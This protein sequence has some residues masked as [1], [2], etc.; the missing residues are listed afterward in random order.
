MRIFRFVLA[1]ALLA[2]SSVVMAKDS[3]MIRDIT[4]EQVDEKALTDA[5]ASRTLSWLTGSSSN[6]DYMSVGRM[7]NYFGFVGLRVASGHSLS[8]SQVAKQTLSVLD[9]QQRNTLLALLEQ[10][11]APFEQVAKS[12]FAMNRALEGLLIGESI[13][14][15]NSSNLGSAMV[16]MKPNSA[17]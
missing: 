10:Q 11:K 8:R 6:N 14:E 17:K 13:S 7:A 2:S 12:R 16:S 3:D 4:R 5:I 15:K 9:S 1:I